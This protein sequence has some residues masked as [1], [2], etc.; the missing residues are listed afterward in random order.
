MFNLKDKQLK[1]EIYLVCLDYREMLCKQLVLE[2]LLELP[3]DALQKIYCR[4]HFENLLTFL[5]YR[6]GCKFQRHIQELQ[7][8]GYLNLTFRLREVDLRIHH[9]PFYCATQI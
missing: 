8:Y 4:S 9:C 2:F 5:M 3:H 7:I 6:L 1:K